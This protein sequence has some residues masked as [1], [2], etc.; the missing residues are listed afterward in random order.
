MKPLQGFRDFYPDELA[1]RNHIFNAWR[2]VACRYGFQEYDGPPLESLE[3]YTR[4]SGD[5]IVDQLYNFKDK[6]E[7]DVALRPEMTPTLA[8][9]MAARATSLPKPIKWFSIPQLFRYERKQR[10]RLREHFQLNVDI[11]GAPE[12]EADVELLAVGLDIQ[13]A[14]G[15]TETDVV[16]RVN[17]RRITAGALKLLEVSEEQIPA[18]YTAVDKF[19]KVPPETFRA[20][21]GEAGVP[22][23]HTEELA[24]LCSGN[25]HF[26][27]W[28]GKR[29]EREGFEEPRAAL[30]DLEKYWVQLEEQGFGNF[31]EVDP[32]IV[33]GLAYYTGIVFELYD[34]KGELRAICGGGRYDDLIASL[35]GPDMPAV[36]FGMGDVVL[37]E[38][39][40]DRN[41]IPE[42]PGRIEASVIAVGAEMASAARKVT[43][44]L[45]QAGI[46]AETPYTPIGVGKDLKAA[47]Q[48]KADYAVIIGPDEWASGDVNLKD[49]RSGEQNRLSMEKVIETIQGQKKKRRT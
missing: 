29:L 46:A 2:D 37:S 5:E 13:R 36:G 21:L 38:L 8:R 23:S 32:S 42:A 45:R 35:G 3:L 47:N 16:A 12:V 18:V 48:A 19:K 25:T 27:K 7:R 41:L 49:L 31:V 43:A 20:L 10:G 4:K 6:G 30:E 33:R 26:S 17:D 44:K 22:S 11:V 40:R 28:F 39:L 9:M 14:L 15:L 34:R 24:E 1:R